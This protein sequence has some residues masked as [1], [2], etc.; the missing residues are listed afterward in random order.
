MSA[1]GKMIR[2]LGLTQE[3]TQQEQSMKGLSDYKSMMIENEAFL[4]YGTWESDPTG[5]NIVWTDGMYGIFG[6]DHEDKKKLVVN[7]ELY[8]AHMSAAEDQKMKPDIENFLAGKSEYHRE[9]E[10]RDKQGAVKILSTY[11]KVIRNMRT[12]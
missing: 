9:I 3:I 12:G 10:I 6:Y 5:D 7:S 4:K 11:A 1:D 2:V 8:N